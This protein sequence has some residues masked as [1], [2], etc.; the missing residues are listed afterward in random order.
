M[1][2]DC[3][4][5][6]ALHIEANHLEWHHIRNLFAAMSSIVVLAVQNLIQHFNPKPILSTP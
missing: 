3:S 1:L 5:V 4:A 6:D 2:L